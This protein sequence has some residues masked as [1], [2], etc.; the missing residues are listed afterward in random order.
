MRMARPTDKL[1]KVKEFYEKGLGLKKIGG[2][3][4]HNGYEGV[5]YGL[6]DQG[7]HLEFTSHEE[8]TP[9]PAPT[10]DNLLVFYMA[11]RK[12]LERITANLEALG[13]KE[14]KP[15]NSY[16]ETDGKTFEDP[17]GW[18]VVL[19]HSPGIL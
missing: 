19:M 4:G 10:K 3:S 9:C 13:A 14:A 7:V 5:M 12:A 1:E 8:G 2:F 15:E 16:W 17:D 11:D 18:R 6:P